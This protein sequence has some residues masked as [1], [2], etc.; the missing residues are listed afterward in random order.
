[1]LSTLML[2]TVLAPAAANSPANPC[3]TA[4]GEL[5]AH[6]KAPGNSGLGTETAVLVE[7]NAYAQHDLTCGESCTATGRASIAAGKP[8]PALLG[9]SSVAV[10]GFTAHPLTFLLTGTDNGARLRWSLRGKTFEADVA[11][12]AG[13]LWTAAHGSKSA[14]VVHITKLPPPK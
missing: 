13:G 8:A 10:P 11:S 3:S 6:L 7:G 4:L 1:M 12:C 9:A 2:V 14:I 5:V